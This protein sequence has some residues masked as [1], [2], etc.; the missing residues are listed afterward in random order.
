ML[1]NSSQLLLQVKKIQLGIQVEKGVGST[2]VYDECVGPGT[3]KVL[4]MV[5]MVRVQ[6]YLSQE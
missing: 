5:Q 2:G 6:R 4:A 3:V 1:Y